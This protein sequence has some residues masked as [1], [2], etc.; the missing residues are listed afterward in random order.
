MR[1]HLWKNV[2]PLGF[3]TSLNQNG[4]WL[5]RDAQCLQGDEEDGVPAGSL[6]RCGWPGLF[7][8]YLCG[9]CDSGPWLMKLMVC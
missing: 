3:P 6:T 7:P 2:L 1:A 9:V 8:G 5:K 4:L